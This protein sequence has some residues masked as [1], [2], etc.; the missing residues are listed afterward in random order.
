MKDMNCCESV[1]KKVEQITQAMEQATYHSDSPYNSEEEEEEGPRIIETYAM[2]CSAVGWSTPPTYRL[3]SAAEV[4]REQ[5]Q[6][7]YTS[8]I[9]QALQQYQNGETHT[10]SDEQWAHGNEANYGIQDGVLKKA[11]VKGKGKAAVTVW[12]TV[13]PARLRANVIQAFHTRRR[14]RISGLNPTQSPSLITCATKFNNR[15]WD[16]HSVE[17]ATGAN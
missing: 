15:R 7:T 9:R 12:Q 13:V 5:K 10:P 3:P 11:W 4:R 16:L 6:E 8:H 14:K 1:A 17:S 2:V